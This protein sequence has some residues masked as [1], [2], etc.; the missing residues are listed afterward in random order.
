MISDDKQIP[1][2]L[3]MAALTTAAT[4]AAT[5][6]QGVRTGSPGTRRKRREKKQRR[7]M[8]KKSRRRNR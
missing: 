4:A 1:E 8:A 7:A 2:P 5:G 3:R 6:N